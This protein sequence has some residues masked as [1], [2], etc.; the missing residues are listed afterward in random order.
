[1]VGAEEESKVSL[2]MINPQAQQLTLLLVTFGNNDD[3]PA[4][5]GDPHPSCA[6]TELY[7]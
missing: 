7:L 5:A 2:F 1:M 6:A 4:A 3:E